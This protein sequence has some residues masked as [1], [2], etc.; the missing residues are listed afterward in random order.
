MKNQV[1]GNEP[2]ELEIVFFFFF[3]F[4]GGGGGSK[5][6]GTFEKRTPRDNI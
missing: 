6:F 2:G 4:F 3:F 1:S 5:C